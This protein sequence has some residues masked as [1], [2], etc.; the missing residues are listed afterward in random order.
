V[1]PLAAT[2]GPSAYWYLTRATGAVALLLLTI[3][4]ALGVADVR[5]I[6]TARVP[7]FV[8]DALHRNAA[9]LSVLFLVIHIATTLL[10]GFA[11]ISLLA[12]F[13]P[14]TSSYRPLWLGLGAASCDLL[15]AL[16]ASSLLRRHLGHRTWQAI[17]WCAYACWPLALI[18]GLGTGS[19]AKAGW[20]LALTLVC[21]AT[22]LGAVAVRVWRA[23]PE[24][25]G[26]RASAAFAALAFIVFIAVWLPTGPLG[27]EWARRSGTPAYLLGHAERAHTEANDRAVRTASR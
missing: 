16:V 1:L 23:A 11:P 25:T 9:L 14:F 17:H 5:R 6:S 26:A 4:V 2:L 15:I 18:H 22:V 7:R 27:A 21:I 13:I 8:I 10:D 19:D 12:A 20:L 24:R 3:V